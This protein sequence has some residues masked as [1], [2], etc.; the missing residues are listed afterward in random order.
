MRLAVDGARATHSE[1][2]IGAYGSRCHDQ[3]T[4]A[5]FDEWGLDSVCCHP[6]R[7]VTARLVA[8]QAPLGRGSRDLILSQERIL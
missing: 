8:N 5:L 4:M 6:L 7:L 3:G 2:E 1:I